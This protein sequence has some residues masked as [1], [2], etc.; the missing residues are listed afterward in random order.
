LGFRYLSHDEKEGTK[1]LSL[2]KHILNK[3]IKN[4]IN[5][6]ISLMQVSFKKHRLTRVLNGFK[7]G[8]TNN[9]LFP[10]NL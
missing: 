5:N 8:I 4:L 6:N 3:P 2:F 10:K 9:S 1:D 7:W